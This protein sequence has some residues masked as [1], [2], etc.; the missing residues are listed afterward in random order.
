MSQLTP[1]GT[2]AQ[3]NATS[4]SVTGTWGTGQT[5]ASGS[6]LVAMVSAVGSTSA[7]AIANT[8]GYWTKY[9]QEASTTY[10]KVACFWRVADGSAND[11]PTFTST[12]SGTYTGMAATLY[13]FTGAPASVAAIA[14][15][16]LATGT[17][18]N[19]LTPLA[20]AAVI[21]VDNCYALACHAIYR[22][23]TAAN[24]WTKD[25]AWT[26]DTTNGATSQ[27][28]HS[29]ADHL[30]SPAVGAT[31]TCQGATSGCTWGS[32]PT[33]EGALMVVIRGTDALVTP[34]VVAP[35]LL[36]CRIPGVTTGFAIGN[37]FETGSDGTTISNANSGGGSDT[38]FDVIN[39]GTGCTTAFDAANAAHGGLCG[40]IAAGTTAASVSAEWTTAAGT[41]KTEYFRLY[42]K[43]PA[44]PVGINPR[45]YVARNSSGVACGI[46]RITPGGVISLQSG[47]NGTPVQCA[48]FTTPVNVGSYFRIEGY[49]TGDAVEG[50][51]SCSLYNSP[52]SA[53]PTE[54]QSATAL[55]N[56]GLISQRMA[57]KHDSS[58]SWGVYIDEW[59]IADSGPIGPWTSAEVD[60]TATPAVVSGAAG[61][62]GVATPSTPQPTVLVGAVA[63]PGQT[64]TTV[65]AATPAVVTAVAAITAPLAVGQGPP[66]FVQ[67]VSSGDTG[68][69]GS[70]AVTVDSGVTTH[71]GNLVALW[72]RVSAGDRLTGVTDS[73]GNAWTVHIT[74]TSA[75]TN[76]YLASCIIG[77]GKVLT[78]GDTISVVMSGGHANE[79][80]AAEFSGV[81]VSGG[82]AVAER[83]TNAHSASTPAT[84]TTAGAVATPGDL[85]LTVGTAST[86]GAACSVTAADPASGGTWTEMGVPA[87]GGADAA[88]QIGPA[89]ATSFSATW[90][91]GATVVD[92]CLVAFQPVVTATANATAAPAM[93]ATG[94]TLPVPGVTGGAPSRPALVRSLITDVSGGGTGSR[95]LTIDAGADTIAGHLIVLWVRAGA[96]DYL[97]GVTD[98]RGNTW[99]VDEAGS[100]TSSVTSMASCIVAA[101]KVLQAGDTI[102]IV[103]SSVHNNEAGAAEFSGAAAAAGMPITEQA[104]NVHTGSGGALTVATPG[105]VANLGDLAVSCAGGSFDTAAC[106]VTAADPA[107]GGT[108]AQI[109]SP[110]F[111]GV[112]A[113][114]QA[115]GGSLTGFSAAWTAGVTNADGC[116][117]CYKGLAAGG[118]AT[119]K[120]ATVTGSSVITGTP[121]VGADAHVTVSRLLAQTVVFNATLPMASSGSRV[122]DLIGFD[123]HSGDFTTTQ[124]AIG[125]GETHRLFYQSLPATFDADGSPA[126]VTV[127]ASFKAQLTQA[128]IQPY[129]HTMPAGRKLVLIYHHEPEGDY[130]TGAQFVSEFQQ[131]S[132]RIRAAASAEGR[133]ADVRVC[134]CSAGAP[135]RPAANG[136]DAEALAGNYLRGLGPYVDMFTKDVY[137]GSGGTS[138]TY[139]S[140]NGLANLSYWT[141]WLALVTDPSVVGTIKPL[142]ITEYGVDDPVGNTA[143][144]NRIALDRDY[145]AN[146][147]PPKKTSITPYRLTC[148]CYWYQSIDINTAKF[149]D[150]ATIGLWQSIEAPQSTASRAAPPMIARA[151]TI[152]APT[153]NAAQR[154]SP[155]CVA[156]ATAIP[157]P[158]LL[159]SPAPA[160]V[161]VGADIFTPVLTSAIAQDFEQ[162]T[163]GVSISPANSGGSG[164]T[165]FDAV[166]S[167]AAA[168]DASRS[169]HGHQSGKFVS[170]TATWSA[171][172]GA[173]AARLWF[174]QYVSLDANLS[175]SYR[176][177]EFIS[178]GSFAAGIYLNANGTLSFIPA[179]GASVTTVNA[180]PLGVTFWRIEGY[181]IGDAVSGQLELK[182]FRITDA[183]TPTETITSG[184]VG[185]AGLLDTF[186]IGCG[187]GTVWQDDLALSRTG[188]PG[189]VS[190]PPRLI[191]ATLARAATLPAPSMPA[192]PQP[193]VVAGA[194]A[195]PGPVI[196][197]QAGALATPPVV[198]GSTAFPARSMPATPQPGVVAGTRTIAAPAVICTPQPPVLAAPASIPAPAVIAGTSVTA[199]PPVVTIVALI[200]APAHL[201]F[202][203]TAAAPALVPVPALHM[204]ALAAASCVS[205]LAAMGQ[206]TIPVQMEY[207]TARTG[208][209]TPGA[210]TGGRVPGGRAGG[211]AAWR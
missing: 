72:G 79:I 84:I 149:T 100:A 185:T 166:Y 107:S 167:S 106:A 45:I 110:G 88:W 31:L 98:S 25:S 109:G 58:A 94:L 16:G 113:A 59:A 177:S 36:T 151:A 19:P 9:S 24:T 137:Q 148:W 189:P 55:Q 71:A 56:T 181:V 74:G 161:N 60:A 99:N 200:P 70:R 202:P 10:I 47:G 112:D 20:S 180:V 5:H 157:A 23:T 69:S 53:T 134:M 81:G 118:A 42:V 124:A 43:M 129:I 155:A 116:I 201:A 65:S 133:S 6:L 179:S 86:Q 26:N 63:F 76:S 208:S 159:A 190:A 145:L 1:V 121:Q 96:G 178:G 136:G 198:A 21:P 75:Q 117:V 90:A 48:I 41:R 199:S 163:D 13:Q 172:I 168:Y 120:P 207:G 194:T 146:N 111:G 39:T 153:I 187:S 77:T 89:S 80:G 140:S 209:G 4:G 205:A 8:G 188:Y 182:L 66:A 169:A 51:M 130:T 114:W 78:A 123:V 33:Y 46:V 195:I 37:S 82:G 105:A 73:R 142:G 83:P 170:T 173:P 67:A 158:R 12:L 165:A 3:A 139:W 57:G 87:A 196:S 7:A 143:R 49:I 52:E 160:L 34:A 175:G 150:A 162:G 91:C 138:G 64:V 104:G 44:V 131:E 156:A 22:S 15:Y 154:V 176:I 141:S 126:S 183:A 68:G 203:G 92:M 122:A 135:Y 95:D 119:A 174:R 204:S 144:Y 97:T 193:P 35:G 54:T 38:A 108:W 102:S 197:A 14:T 101:G 32:A 85:V 206:A 211:G 128:Q 184:V 61:F 28:P 147:F 2:P 62:G 40:Y 50:A 27:R 93:V 18:A 127:F 192:T 17:T 103:M 152:P 191:P 29:A 125:P 164:E 210:S 11:T 30:A 115:G 171:A 186:W 132:T